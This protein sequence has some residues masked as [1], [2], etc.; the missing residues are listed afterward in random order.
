MTSRRRSRVSIAVL[1]ILSLSCLCI[2]A[3]LTYWGAGPSL[4]CT[5]PE[6]GPARSGWSARTVVSGGR[7][8]CYHLY[9]PPGYDPARPVPVVMSLHGF[10][11]NPD[12]QAW[13]SSWHE[14]GEREGFLVVYPQ[15]TS[16]P[17][18]W[19]AGATWG[20]VPVDDVGFFRDLL[21]DVSR[22]AAV[23]RS[24]VYVNGFS[25]GGGMSVRIGCEAADRVAAIGSVA[26]AVVELQDCNLSHPVPVLAFHGTADPIVPYAGG[27][28]RW[29]P[30]RGGAELTAAPIYFVGAE[31]WVAAWAGGNGCDP[32]PESIPPHGDVRGQRY[33]GCAG[34]AEVI[35]YTIAEGGH[36]W[37]GGPWLPGVGKTSTDIDATE[38]MW[39]FFQAYRLENQP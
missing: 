24:R 5:H 1:A 36:T 33:S 16:F 4:R 19:N 20:V 25:N 10:L 6:R 34:E 17:Q 8:R 7:E 35:L 2:T 9:V 27:E 21:D 38:E 14:L 30:L 12:S 39:R 22:V 13:I 26:G 18:R 23:D 3:A 31:A 15:G 37:P 32:T 28:M 29:R 11:S